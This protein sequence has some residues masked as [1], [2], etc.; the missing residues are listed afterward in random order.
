MS[1][2]ARYYKHTGAY[3]CGYDLTPTPLTD[4]LLS[5]GMDIHFEDDPGKIPAKIVQNKY[6]TLVIFTPALPPDHKELLWFKEK[7]YRIIKRSAALGQIAEKHI[8]LAVAG[9]HGKT[10]TSTLLAHILKHS[11]TGCT[12]FLG[13]ISKNYHTNLLLSDSGFLV[14]EADEYDRSFLQ[15]HPQSAVITSAQADHLDIYGTHSAIIEAFGRFASQITRGGSLL[16]KKGVHIPLSLQED[17]TLFTYDY[18]EPCD[19]YACNARP[20]AGGKYSFDLMLNGHRLEGCTLGIPGKIH[21]ENAVAAAGLAY[22]NGIEPAGIREA[23]AAFN[24]V[25]RRMDVR[26]LTN[27]CCY[28]DDYAHHPAEIKATVLSV[29]E[30]FPNRKITGIFQ[31]HLYSRTRDFAAAFAQSLDLLDQVVL[32]PIYPA[33]EAPL[34]GV[35]SEMLGRMLTVKEHCVLPSSQVVDFVKE[36]RPQVLLTMGAGNIDQLVHPITE[37]LKEMGL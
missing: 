35:S 20:S 28:I 14:A 21:V 12:A 1:A 5:E 29:K 13:G 16:L 23:L 26:Y 15:L 19:F 37:C 6:K 36:H 17:I 9:T 11:G 10:T 31:P 2:L 32:M 4:A 30:W 25:A 7:E 27:G 34:P 33:R 3:V 22:I 24:G 18:Q 8:T